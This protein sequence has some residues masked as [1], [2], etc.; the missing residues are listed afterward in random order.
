MSHKRNIYLQPC[1]DSLARAEELDAMA[2]EIMTRISEET[3]TEI[4]SFAIPDAAVSHPD[5]CS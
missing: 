5:I 1:A 2:M 4:Y 3:S